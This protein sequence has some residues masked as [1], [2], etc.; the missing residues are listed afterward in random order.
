MSARSLVF[1]ATLL[2]VALASFVATVRARPESKGSGPGVLN[3]LRVSDEQREAILSADATFESDALAMQREVQAQRAALAE[4]LVSETA[5][6]ELILAQI[7]RVNTAEH[8]L[9]RR[10]TGY[11]LKVRHHLTP[12]QR[13][14][15]MK[16]AAERM[17]E[18]G[19]GRGGGRGAG[20][21]DGEGRGSRRNRAGE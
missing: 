11:L 7:E 16:L 4:A 12:E 9:E 17:C 8:A 15:L 13:L 19:H 20:R 5:T 10:V 2:L 21:G 3:W 1:A 14:R 18:P 6:D